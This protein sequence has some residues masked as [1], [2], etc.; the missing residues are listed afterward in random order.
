VKLAL[1][2]TIPT[3]ARSTADGATHAT[4][5]RTNGDGIDCGAGF[6]FA[7]LTFVTIV[8]FADPVRGDEQGMYERERDRQRVDQLRAL[9]AQLEQLPRTPA[10]DRLLR[11]AHHRA[12]AVDTGVPAMSGWGDGAAYDPGMLFQHMALAGIPRF[13][14][15]R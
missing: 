5:Q 11:E 12:V 8:T 15:Q 3:E 2:P 7:P 9:A 6:G 4:R 13:A 1:R 10:R 14:S